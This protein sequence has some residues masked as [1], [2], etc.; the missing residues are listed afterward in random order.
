[1]NIIYKPAECNRQTTVKRQ[2]VL[3]AGMQGCLFFSDRKPHYY[4]C[5]NGEIINYYYN[6]Y[7]EHHLYIIDSDLKAFGINKVC[8]VVEKTSISIVLESLGPAFYDHISNTYISHIYQNRVSNVY[9]F[10]SN[11]KFKGHQYY[12]FITSQQIQSLKELLLV[13]AKDHNIPTSYNTEMWGL[14]KN[15]LLGIPGIWT[16]NSFRTDVM[17]PHPQIELVNLLKSL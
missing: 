1:M 8:D 16:H 4:I 9:E 11:A 7:W 2:I 3:H 15:A 14:S 17:D 12:D 10:C 13:L 5:K 6:Q